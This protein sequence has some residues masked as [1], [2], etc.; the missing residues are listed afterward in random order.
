M[1][2]LEHVLVGLGVGVVITVV[3]AVLA[4]R[5]H[6][7]ERRLLATLMHDLRTPLTSLQLTLGEL[8]HHEGYTADE[9]D[10]LTRAIEEAVAL[11][12]F[13][14]NLRIV[15][16][17]ALEAGEDDMRPIEVALGEQVERLKYRYGLVA[18]VRGASL[19]V[20]STP[21]TVLADPRL[22]ELILSNIVELALFGRAVAVRVSMSLEGGRFAITCDAPGAQLPVPISVESYGERRGGN[23]RVEGMRTL[24]AVAALHASQLSG[25]AFVRQAPDRLVVSGPLAKS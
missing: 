1:E 18:R 7:V 20:E 5:R 4:R 25:W 16:V 6:E 22:V 13:L 8:S 17:A 12:S 21:A 10:S 19:L 3:V 23:D 15:E 14:E 24:A 2:P 11:R 9:R